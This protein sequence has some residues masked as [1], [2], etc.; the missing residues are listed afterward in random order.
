MLLEDLR[1]WRLLVLT[2]GHADRLH[3][4]QVVAQGHVGGRAQAQRQGIDEHPE[5]LPGIGQCVR[6]AAAGDA[7][8]DLGVVVAAGQ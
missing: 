5:H 3:L 2:H 7:E 6:A 8:H 1:Q 4:L